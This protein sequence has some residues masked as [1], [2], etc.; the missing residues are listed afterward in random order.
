MDE[1]NDA[2]TIE[3]TTIN[4]RTVTK[5][6]V[7]GGLA[8]LFA[9][10]GAGHALADSEGVYEGGDRVAWRDGKTIVPDRPDR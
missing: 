9:A 6:A 7:A 5:G 10:V 2:A 3:E 8:A 4:R 1:R